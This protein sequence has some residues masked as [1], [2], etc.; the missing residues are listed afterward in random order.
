MKYRPS[1][2]KATRSVSMS[3]SLRHTSMTN[4]NFARSRRAG[5]CLTGRQAAQTISLRT[6]TVQKRIHTARLPPRRTGL[7]PRPSDRQIF[8]SGNR[9]GRCR[10]L[11]GFLGGL[12]FPLP[13]HSGAA[14]FSPHFT[15]FGSQDL[16]FDT[17]IDVE[18]FGTNSSHLEDENIRALSAPDSHE[19]VYFIALPTSGLR[20]KIICE[21]DRQLT[22]TDRVASLERGKR[23]IPEKTHRPAASSGTIS[24]CENPEVSRPGIEPGSPWWEA[25]SLTAKNCHALMADAG[26]KYGCLQQTTGGRNSRWPPTADDDGDG[27]HDGG[28][29]NQEREIDKE[30]RK[31]DK[32]EIKETGRNMISCFV[33]TL[34][35]C[36]ARPRLTLP[37][38]ALIRMDNY[39]RMFVS[40]SLGSDALSWSRYRP[41]G[42]G[43]PSRLRRRRWPSDIGRNKYGRQPPGFATF[44]LLRPAL[45][46]IPFPWLLSKL[47]SP[48]PTSH[49]IVAACT[50]LQPSAWWCS[51]HCALICSPSS[52]PA[53]YRRHATGRR[54]LAVSTQRVD[55]GT[56]WLACA[57]LIEAQWRVLTIGDDATPSHSVLDC[58]QNGDAS[59]HQR[60]ASQN[61]TLR[62]DFTPALPKHRVNVLLALGV[63]ICHCFSGGGKGVKAMPHI[64]CKVK[65]REA[66]VSAAGTAAY[67]RRVGRQ[68]RKSD[69]SKI[70]GS[71]VYIQNSISPLDCQSIKEYVTLRE[72]FEESRDRPGEEEG[73]GEGRNFEF[74]SLRLI[75][76]A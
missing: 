44:I 20:Q 1:T 9:A 36:L 34:N 27:I 19:N 53:A 15:H 2:R 59:Q 65:C 56:S 5:R 64:G 3:A 55:E 38:D 61:A 57:W 68:S 45:F 58:L 41:A 22:P 14:P 42:L 11:T 66:I 31:D 40:V 25:S 37:G 10:W 43:R 46:G 67:H 8:V 76:S 17:A 30:R 39:P 12:L 26:I 21:P 51:Q 73:E 71:V 69:A 48:W 32:R 72:D 70:G 33:K 13:L 49:C 6:K 75:T 16:V 35:D 29:E 24:T 28:R 18:T 7:N 47:A 54:L 63:V 62:V 4:C 74:V 50:T 23:E 60:V 52:G